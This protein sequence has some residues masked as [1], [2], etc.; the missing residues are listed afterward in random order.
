MDNWILTGPRTLTRQ[1]QTE[2]GVGPDEVKVKITHVLISN[3]DALTYSGELRVRYPKTLG[4]FAVGVVTDAGDKVYGV[5]KGA[6]VYVKATRPCKKC[7][8]CRSGSAADCENV[9]IA[10]RDFDGFLRDFVV[11]DYKDVAPLPDSVDV[12]HALCIE[13]VALAEN[14]YDKLDLSAGS[15]VAIIGSNF[16][17]CILAQVATYHKYVPIIID[18]NQQNLEKLRRY[19]VYFA[20]MQDETLEANVADAT[21]GNMC[22]AAI[23]TPCSRLNPNLAARVLARGK[24]LVLGTFSPIDFKLDALPILERNLHVMGISDG[25]GYTE[26]A[27]NM[28]T[29][30]AVD[31]TMFETEILSD[32]E[33]AELLNKKLED[34]PHSNKM[35]VIKLIL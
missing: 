21:G 9:Q 14:I 23:Y 20:F 30:G 8:Q 3:Y 28:I 31:L 29:H 4:R 5:E 12:M 33:P 7:L 35:S 15:K 25:Y 27:I 1:P 26:A 19:G 18:N 32:C 10:G 13:N 6:N 16:T 22:D 17:A 34:V 11:C 24:K 2:M